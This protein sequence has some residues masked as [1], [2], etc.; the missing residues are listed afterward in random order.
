MEHDTPGQCDSDEDDPLRNFVISDV[1]FIK[2]TH[3][4]CNITALVK[5]DFEISYG[6]EIN[7]LG[8][9][10]NPIEDFV[11]GHPFRLKINL[12]REKRSIFGNVESGRNKLPKDGR[13]VKF[14]IV[15][16]EV[17]DISNRRYL[18]EVTIA[19]ALRERLGKSQVVVQ[20]KTHSSADR[21]QYQQEIVINVEGGSKSTLKRPRLEKFL[22]I[23]SSEQSK[24]IEVEYE[25]DDDIGVLINKI[26]IKRRKTD[27]LRKIYNLTQITLK[28]GDEK[29][30]MDQRVKDILED[31]GNPTITQ[32]IDRPARSRVSTP[33]QE[34]AAERAEQMS[35]ELIE[36][37]TQQAVAPVSYSNQT[38]PVQ[39]N[40][41][42][43]QQVDTVPIRQLTL[44][45]ALP[46]STFTEM[47][48]A[49]NATLRQLKELVIQKLNEG[50]FDFD[51]Y[52][53]P[54]VDNL[55]LVRSGIELQPN[56][57]ALNG[58]NLAN[59]DTLISQWPPRPAQPQQGRVINQNQAEEAEGAPPEFGRSEEATKIRNL[60]IFQRNFKECVFASKRGIDPAD[61][62]RY[63][64]PASEPPANPVVSDLGDP[65]DNIGNALLE[66]SEQLHKTADIL[67]A[68]PRYGDNVDQLNT[69]RRLIDNNMQAARYLTP[70][71][72]HLTNFIIPIDRTGDNPRRFRVQRNA[73]N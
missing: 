39:P 22:K 5:G 31:Y 25:S 8:L 60:S 28:C 23:Y 47:S 15:S 42:P 36:Q 13:P 27:G 72:K 11:V 65:L 54:T 30:E 59:N 55:R 2:A 16:D 69:D 17:F 46:N 29:L 4:F 50:V 24:I 32:S 71:I 58:L 49:E 70:V 48:I 51:Q 20:G 45:V 40:S 6:R 35:P 7:I 64:D 14:T 18:S 68:D 3:A 66:W 52:G 73:E 1:N 10:W 57:A 56:D 26:N 33:V 38:V 62:T 61:R 53:H 41:A 12:D 19:D 67:V 37:P 9:T 63:N 44:K 34:Q 43:V 21:N